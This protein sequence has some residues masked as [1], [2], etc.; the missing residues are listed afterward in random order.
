MTDKSSHSEANRVMNKFYM[1]ENF[2]H[3]G[4][5][6][7]T[8]NESTNTIVTPILTSPS[9]WNFIQ[10]PIFTIEQVYE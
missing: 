1:F 8:D 10:Y 5:V 4:T 7:A 2:S 9:V 3:R 6:E